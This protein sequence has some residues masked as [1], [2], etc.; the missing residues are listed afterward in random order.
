MVGGRAGIGSRMMQEVAVVGGRRERLGT[1]SS[2][3]SDFPVLCVGTSSS[4]SILRR[5]RQPIIH[6]NSSYTP[7]FRTFLRGITGTKGRFLP[8]WI[9]ILDL[10]Y[11]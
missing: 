5:W 7:T 3:C 8:S 6:A 10:P 2:E 1:S 9:A 11:V 4:L